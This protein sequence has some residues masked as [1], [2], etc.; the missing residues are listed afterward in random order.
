MLEFILDRDLKTN[1]EIIPAGTKLPLRS[2]YVY[3]RQGNMLFYIGSNA[4]FA[5]G[6]MTLTEEAASKY[7]SG[8]S[9]HDGENNV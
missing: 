6:R 5:Y 9:I 1:Y 7:E 8:K 4:A 2:G 3:D